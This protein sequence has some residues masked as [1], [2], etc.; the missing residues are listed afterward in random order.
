MTKD[1][2]V[3]PTQE[4]ALWTDKRLDT[5]IARGHA[6]CGSHLSSYEQSATVTGILLRERK[7]RLG[8]GEWLPWL[9]DHF[10]GNR[11]TAVRYMKMAD[12]AYPQIG[13]PCPI[14]SPV[15]TTDD[16][17]EVVEG[18][19]VEEEASGQTE[20]RMSPSIIEVDLRQGGMVNAAV[21]A[22]NLVR[23]VHLACAGTASREE[24]DQTCEILSNIIEMAQAAIS[25]IQRGGQGK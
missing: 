10:E 13:H 24:K 11:R 17:D 19:V 14:S 2:V 25:T 6:S 12:V 16:G 20:P 4:V 18:E 23:A 22:Q 9:R 3:P 21:S 1:L 7:R 15:E 8:H 5:A